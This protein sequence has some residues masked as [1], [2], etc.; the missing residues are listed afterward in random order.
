MEEFI[1]IQQVCV[2]EAQRDVEQKTAKLTKEFK[3]KPTGCIFRTAC[4]FIIINR[5]LLNQVFPGSSC[6]LHQ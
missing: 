5:Y 6:M 3:T 1:K 2:E 4:W